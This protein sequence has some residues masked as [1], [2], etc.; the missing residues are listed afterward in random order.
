M[1]LP[2]LSAVIILLY[3]EEVRGSAKAPV[4]SL[5]VPQFRRYGRKFNFVCQQVGIC[6]SELQDEG[7][8]TELPWGMAPGLVFPDSLFRAADSGGSE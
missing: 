3:T 7:L 5:S 4:K 2:C 8:A 6:K 1:L